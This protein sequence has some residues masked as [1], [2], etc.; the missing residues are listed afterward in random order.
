MARFLGAS[1]EG[2]L[3]EVFQRNSSRKGGG[4]Q[5]SDT[6]VLGRAAAADLQAFGQTA[7]ACKGVQMGLEANPK[8]FYFGTFFIWNAFLEALGNRK[9]GKTM[10]NLAGAPRNRK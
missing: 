5:W 2:V 7:A 9:M 1:K 6:P 8:G 3:G 10:R 4:T